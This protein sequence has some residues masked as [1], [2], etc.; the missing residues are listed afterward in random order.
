MNCNISTIPYSYIQHFNY[1]QSN[2]SKQQMACNLDLSMCS[3]IE[4]NVITRYVHDTT[5]GYQVS[6]SLDISGDCTVSCDIYANLVNEDGSH[7]II[8]T[9]YDNNA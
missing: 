9:T 6:G 4:S 7:Q 3:S 5:N 8:L 1:I 2:F